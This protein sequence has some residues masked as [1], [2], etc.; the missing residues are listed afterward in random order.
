MICKT[1]SVAETLMLACVKRDRQAWRLP[2]P[3]VLRSLVVMTQTVKMHC[4]RHSA[5]HSC[6]PAIAIGALN[7]VVCS[8]A[9][10][11]LLTQLDG[12]IATDARLA[13]G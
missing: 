9:A 12:S 6:K 2:F 11:A 3:L 1:V 7:D 5:V 4:R 13:V 10:C 8:C